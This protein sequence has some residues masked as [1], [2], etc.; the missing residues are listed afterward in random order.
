MTM[1][2][3]NLHT[4]SRLSKQHSFTIS[5]LFG[6]K[7][8]LGTG[9]SAPGRNSYRISRAL[10]LLLYIHAVTQYEC[11]VHSCAI[12]LVSSKLNIN[13]KDN[14]TVSQKKHPRRF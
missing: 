4:F 5:I 7:T 11:H 9:S 14:Y 8:V 10:L 6:A 12:C 13:G 2:C 3:T 1:T